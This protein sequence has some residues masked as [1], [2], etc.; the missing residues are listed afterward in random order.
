MG[1]AQKILPHY[2]YDDYIQ[3]EGRWELIDGHPIAM[4]PSPVPKHQKISSRLQ[5]ELIDALEDSPCK[6]CEV[7]GPI[8]YKIEEDTILQPDV[9]IVC[10][11]ITQK[12]LDFPPALVVE[13]LSPSTALRDRNTKYDIYESQGI[14][15]YLIVDIDK[16]SFELF[17]LKEGKYVLAEY[18]FSQSFSFVF[19]TDGCGASVTLNN[20]W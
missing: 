2:T 14:R 7:Y 16:E 1:Y 10:N 12:F 5:Y 18:D 19:G 11:E 4:S 15:Y 3:W 20:I 6:K 17:E 13:I 8:D 9:L